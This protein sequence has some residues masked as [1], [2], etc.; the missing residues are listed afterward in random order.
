MKNRGFKQA[1]NVFWLLHSLF[2]HFSQLL[3][4]HKVFT[5]LFKVISHLYALIWWV[6]SEI[7]FIIPYFNHKHV[8]AYSV[9]FI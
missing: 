8:L 3:I 9:E 2:I 7:V 5:D 4:S 6:Q 1:K